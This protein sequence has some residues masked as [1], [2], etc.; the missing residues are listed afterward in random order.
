LNTAGKQMVKV[1]TS[2]DDVKGPIAHA[3][4]GTVWG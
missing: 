2:C 1:C 4:T 3:V